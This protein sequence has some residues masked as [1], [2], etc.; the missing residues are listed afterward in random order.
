MFV[1]H[2]VMTFFLSKNTLSLT[3]N[4]EHQL[5]SPNKHACMNSYAHAYTHCTE[6]V[7]SVS[8]EKDLA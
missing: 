3:N 4:F 8:C 2:T 5:Q 1:T 6:Q 7:V